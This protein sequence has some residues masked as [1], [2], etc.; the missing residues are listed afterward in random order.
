[1]LSFSILALSILSLDLLTIKEVNLQVEASYR[2]NGPCV[3]ID[4]E[5]GVYYA[6]YW[7]HKVTKLDA[8]GRKLFDIG[9][10]GN[11]PGEYFKPM[12][13]C[14][15]NS[16]AVI[17]VKGISRHA[18]LY[19]T[20]SGQYIRQISLEQSGT[21]LPYP[22]NSKKFLVLVGTGFSGY[23]ATLYSDSDEN[24]EKWFSWSSNLRG[25]ESVRGG[26]VNSIKSTFT[27]DPHGEI[28]YS[29]GS[30]PKLMVVSKESE[31]FQ[32]WDLA[33]PLGYK[34]PPEK[35]FQM[36]KMFDKDAVSDYFDSYSQIDQIAYLDDMKMVV[37]WKMPGERFVLDFYDLKTRERDLGNIKAPG[38][39]ITTL[40]STMVFT[41]LVEGVDFDFHQLIFGMIK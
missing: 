39:L 14:L 41:K 9:Q 6:N 22:D 35:P 24:S 4:N 7:D 8:N 2:M 10:A 26:P 36:E 34:A 15:L 40:K 31:I 30:Y 18:N 28:Y 1:M 27:C 21:V 33:I 23:M 32:M 12:H 19:D 13:M 11:G 37:S 29:E 38:R 17:L 5:G 20:S 25:F 3:T 16:E